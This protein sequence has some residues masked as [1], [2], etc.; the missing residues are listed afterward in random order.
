MKRALTHIGVRSALAVYGA[1]LAGARLVR[2]QPRPIDEGGCDVLLTGMFQST[3]W[4][5]HHLRPLA[6][7]ASCRSV[8]LVATTPLAPMDKVSVVQPPRWLIRV[9]GSAGARLLVFTALALRRRPH[10][11]GGFHLLFN[12]L[13]A[14]LVAPLAGARSLYFCVGGPAEVLDG[15]IRAENKLFN[16]LETADPIVEQQ[17]VRATASF[18]TIITMGTSA[19]RFLRERGARGEIHVIPGGLDPLTYQPSSLPPETDVMF[20]GRLAPIKRP[21]LLLD[22]IRLVADR[23]PH[24]RVTIV[25]DGVLRQAL[26]ERS[27]RLGL[28]SNVTFAG[29][30]TDVRALLPRA[31]AFILTSETEGVALSLMEALA[32]GVPSIVPRVGDLADVLI[33]GVNG[34]LVDEHTPEAFASRI[35]DLLADE[36]ARRTMAAAARGSS[37]AYAVP[38]MSRRWEDL[39]RYGGATGVVQAFRPAVENRQG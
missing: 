6:L 34:F 27:S 21:E 1:A 23:L 28:T 35:N 38:A 16:R 14:A 17:L 7:A 26:E 2:R 8:T 29:H 4:V 25:G 10:I 39:L 22:A 9:A 24:V 33:D 18:D 32:C 19:A 11:V 15:G 20:V 31:R 36:P 5:E 30:R 13:T 37:E 12:G 3:S